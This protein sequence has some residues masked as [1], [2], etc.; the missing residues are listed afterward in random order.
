MKHAQVF[1]VFACFILAL[2]PFAAR[3]TTFTLSDSALMSLDYD[4]IYY[5]NQS[6][7][8]T[9]IT[10]VPGPGVQFDISFPDPLEKKGTVPDIFWTS[11][12][13]GGQGIFAHRDIST[14]NSFALKFTLISATGISSPDEVGLLAVGALINQS[15]HTYAYQPKGL[16]FYDPTYPSSAVSITPTDSSQISL[17]GFT[18][19]IP[20]GSAAGNWDPTGAKVSILVQA[21]PNAVVITPEPATLLLLGLG[22]VALRRKRS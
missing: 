10:D 4:F 1:F 22:A 12:I 20:E 2:S 9:K 7:T 18:C 6:G 5:S 19:Y 21:A 13:Y 8:I 11:C 3:G 15:Q 14:Y 17:V 16:T